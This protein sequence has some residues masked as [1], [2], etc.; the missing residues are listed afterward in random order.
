M[1]GKCD[2]NH[3]LP[4]NNVIGRQFCQL[5]RKSFLKTDDEILKEKERLRV[6]RIRQLDTD[7]LKNKIRENPCHPR[8]PCSKLLL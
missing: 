3:V 8:Y 4:M 7:K 6:T 2:S 5:Y 1:F